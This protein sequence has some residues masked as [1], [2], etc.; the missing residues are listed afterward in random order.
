MKTT[1]INE[2]ENINLIR[3]IA[4]SFHKTTGLDVEELISEGILAYYT[5]LSEF[6]ESKGVKLTTFAY[7]VIQSALLNYCSREKK[8]HYIDLEGID[9]AGNERSDFCLDTLFPEGSPRKLIDIVLEIAN[10]YQIIR[11]VDNNK[12]VAIGQKINFQ[13]PPKK[14]RGQII[15]VLREQ[16]W[17]WGE[18]WDSIRSIKNVLNEN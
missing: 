13:M 2:S 16:G 10:D 9:I 12:S 6:D 5:C 7:K 15:R 17:A 11:R 4:W 3:Q 14:I 1:T 18:I 8:H